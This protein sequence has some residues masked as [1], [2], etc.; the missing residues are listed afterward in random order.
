MDVERTMQFILEMQARS[1][2]RMQKWESR[3]EKWD[4]RAE[5]WESR[6]AK[7]EA[8]QERAGARAEA[9]ELLFE[10]RLEAIRKI[11]QQGM[12]TLGK[13]QDEVAKLA[14]SQKATDRALRAFIG[15]MGN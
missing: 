3:A 5:K 13:T 4:S 8:R 7:V 11:L 10:R 14:E 9:R 6:M 1:E 15:S 2:S 12:K